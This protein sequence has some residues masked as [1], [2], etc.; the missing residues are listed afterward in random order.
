MAGLAQSGAGF[1]PAKHFLD[2]LADAQADRIAGVSGGAAVDGRASAVGVLGGVRRDRLDPEVGDE[3]GGVVGLVHPERLVM[4]TGPIADHV[5]RRLAL[6]RAGRP[7][8]PGIDRRAIPVL[9]EHIAHIGQPGRLTRPLR[10]SRASGSVVDAWVSLLRFS[11]WKSR[12]PLRPGPGGV[13]P[14]SFGRKLFM[15]AQATI[16]VPSTEPRRAASAK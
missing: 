2:P 7:R 3:A 16:R 14:P 4:G 12:S 9:H 13:P 1:D 5:Q 10:M 11:P 8:Q 15:L 6:G